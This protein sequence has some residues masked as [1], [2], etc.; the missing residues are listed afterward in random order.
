MTKQEEDRMKQLLQRALPAV[1]A[2]PDPVRD[3]WPAVLKRM[4]EKAGTPPWF[5]W[6]LLGG[7]VGLAAFFPTAIPVILYYL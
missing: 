6:A 3:L 7:L 2:Q 1:E 4:D 5:D